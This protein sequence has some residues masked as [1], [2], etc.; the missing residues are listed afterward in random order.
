M[1]GRDRYGTLTM[2][3]FDSRINST[4]WLLP[5]ALPTSFHLYQATHHDDHTI[6]D[7]NKQQHPTNHR[8]VPQ[9]LLI[10]NYS[11]SRSLDPWPRSQS[12]HIFST[13]TITLPS[14]RH[15]S[16]LF[17]LCSRPLPA[18]FVFRCPRRCSDIG[19]CPVTGVT[20][21]LVLSYYWCF[22][23]YWWFLRLVC[24]LLWPLRLYNRSIDATASSR[25]FLFPAPPCHAIIPYFNPRAAMPHTDRLPP[26]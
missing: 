23:F 5:S 18:A 9:H 4:T 15:L 10:T 24:P 12:W 17:C 22:Y 1:V 21:L 19:V 16:C 3:W 25:P 11:L 20:Q 26:T 13:H 7:N 14:H 6:N 8:A 2:W